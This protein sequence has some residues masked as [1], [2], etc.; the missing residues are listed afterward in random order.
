MASRFL[1]VLIIACLAFALLV[2]VLPA[3]AAPTLQTTE[4][5]TPTTTPTNTSTP[6]PT[7]TPAYISGFTLDSGNTLLVERRY[8]FGELAVFLAV[9][10]NSALFGLHWLYEVTRREAR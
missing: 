1:P 3:S 9:I 7:A 2:R 5:P 6:S 4:T 8:T 10:A